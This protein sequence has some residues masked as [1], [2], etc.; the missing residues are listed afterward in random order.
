MRKLIAAAAF[1]ALV[2]AP[3]AAQN[4]DIEALSGL[5]F[6]FGNPGARA[7]GMGGAFLALADDATAAEANPAGL[8]IL[9]Q[10]EVS[11]EGRHWETEQRFAVGGDFPDLDVGLQI[12]R[13]RRVELNFGSFVM[14]FGNFAIAGYYHQPLAQ[15]TD[16]TVLGNEINF[17]LAP[18][19]PVS[20]AQC[21]QDPDCIPYVLYP[22]RTAVE[23]RMRTTGLAAAYKIGTVSVGAAV[24][25][26]K[27]EQGAFTFRTD[28]DF[29]PLSLVAQ[30]ADD[31]DITYSAGLKWEVT[32]ALSFGAVYKQGAQFDTSLF[33]QDLANAGDVIDIGNPS[34]NV[35]DIYGGGIAFRPIPTLTVLADV[36]NVNY[37]ALADDFYSVFAGIDGDN[38]YEIEDGVE[39]HVGA[40]YF[41]A[42]AI[43]VAIRA[44]W[45][46]EP[47]H[48]LRFT[49][50]LD[51][52]NAVAM[53]ILHPGA[54]DQDHY[55]VGVG[56]AWP[57][58][59]IDAAYD[60]ADTARTGSISFV[61][62]F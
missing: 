48:S 19:G 2:A 29:L 39:Y 47:A 44:G 23:T 16:T 36:V 14:P 32:P 56:L 62:R 9:R 4:T 42:T 49:G 37:S 28:T 7:L 54:E 43:P 52:P 6:S 53:R 11:L 45:W 12:N 1:S 60:T 35:P 38:E 50:E 34:F 40:E 21:D 15:V 59:Q 13:S 3:A 25:Q 58:F 24:R 18:Q 57:R 5:T 55:S 20:P 51:R 10:A 46:R 27:F 41:F 26:Q 30:T 17:Y 31:D 61:T 8:T 33:F 22:F